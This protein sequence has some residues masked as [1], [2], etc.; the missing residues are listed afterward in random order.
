[1]RRVVEMLEGNATRIRLEP[2]GDAGIGIEFEVVIGTDT[3]GEQTKTGQDRWTIN[4]LRKEKVLRAAKAQVCA[5]RNYRFIATTD[6]RE[7]STLAGFANKAESFSDYVEF[8]TAE[9]RSD[10]AEIAEEW[11]VS[12]QDTWRMLKN[13]DVQHMPMDA[14]RDIVNIKLAV[15][16]LDDP[17]T[18][19][20]VLRGFCDKRMHRSFTAPEVL[21]YLES[22]DFRRKLSVGDRGVITKLRDTVET[23]DFRVRSF[24]PDIGLVPR[25]DVSSLVGRLRG[26]ES[27][28]I[29]VVAGTAGSG[30]STVVTAVAKELQDAGWFVAVA[31]MDGHS[32]VSTSF[33]LG[34]AMNLD[35]KPSVLLAGVSNGS[36][37][38]LVIDQ[39]DAASL[40]SGRMPENF[41]AVL[42][43]MHEVKPYPNVKV[44]L[45]T[46]TVDLRNDWRML[47]LLQS[48]ECEDEP[49]TVGK[50]EAQEVKGCLEAN[51]VSI[52]TSATTLELLRTPLHLAVFCRLPISDRAG[53]YTTLQEL[54]AS[55]TDHIR[56]RLERERLFGPANWAMITGA[57]VAYM[58]KHQVLS[59]PKSVLATVS[60]L[61]V[62]TL[63][64]ESVLIDKRDGYAF[65]HESYFDF[66]FAQDFVSLGHSLR[67]FLLESDQGLFRRAQTRQ[68]LEYLAGENRTRFIS[69]VVDLLTS[70]YV[71]F[72]LKDVVIAILRQIRPTGEDWEAL[73]DLAWNGS[74]IGSR[75]ITLLSHGGWFDAVDS[76]GLWEEWLGDPEKA[77]KVFDQV[78]WA[79]KERPTRV[80]ELIRPHIGQSDEWRRRCHMLVAA[81]LNR[82]L[83]DFA[84]ELVEQGQLDDSHDPWSL[85]YPLENDD[86]AGAVRLIGAF[87]QRALIRAQECGL[88]DPFSS[89]HLSSDSQSVSD[90]S[91]MAALE[92]SEF[93]KHVLPFVVAVSLGDQYPIGEGRLPLSKRWV[94]RRRGTVYTVEDAVFAGTC[95]ALEKMADKRPEECGAT[96]Q[97]LRIA[98][99]GEL[100]FL[101]CRA[102]TVMDDP[103]DAIGWLMSDSR[104]LHL[105]WTDNSLWASRELIEKHSSTCSLALL[106]TLEETLLDHLPP[107]EKKWPKWYGYSRYQL[108]S[109]MDT[110]RL[111]TLAKRKL[112][113]LERRFHQSPPDPPRPMEVR[114]AKSPIPEESTQH[115]SDDNWIRAL[116]K[117]ASDQPDWDGPKATGGAFELAQTLGRR[118]KEHPD[119]FARLSLRFDNQI[120]PAA[121]NAVLDNVYETIDSAL[122]TKVC[123]HAANTY[124]LDSGLSTCQAIRRTQTANPTT[125]RIITSYSRAQDDH[126]PDDTTP[127]MVREWAA[128]AAGSVLLSG[129]EHVEDLLPAIETLA[130]D[131]SLRVR[132]G[133]ASAVHVLSNHKPELALDIAEHLFQT[134]EVL[135]SHNSERL[136]SYAV[137]RRVDRFAPILSRALRHLDSAPA[138]RGSQS[139]VSRRAGRIWAMAHLH[140]LKPPSITNNISEL[141]EAARLGAAEALAANIPDSLKILPVLFD[142]DSPEVRQRASFAVRHLAR[143]TSDKQ[144]ELL[145]AL[146]QSRAFSDRKELLFIKLRDLPEKLPRGTIAACELAVGVAGAR[147]GDM[148]TADSGLGV[149]L[150]HVVLRLYRESEEKIRRRC[151]DIIDKL[152]EFNAF[153]IQ[154][155]LDQQRR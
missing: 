82:D 81:S 53:K 26:T 110:S 136:L 123:H 75:L 80:A 138:P 63:I 107:R 135:N 105:G 16:F 128:L 32:R 121:M 7:L 119:R 41:D 34:E 22:K 92:P 147:M 13:I 70:E 15:L 48:E 62:R 67:A 125:V 103:D 145:E 30:K 54:Y 148:R 42:K 144:S 114:S 127:S 33:E 86:P 12:E 50:L 59:S 25:S 18:V 5:G 113:E 154:T 56:L 141:P 51:N 133:A 69:V 57:L 1:M 111:S 43:T 19:F 87:L 101:A 137:L 143:L 84:V 6:A 152:V 120:P 155:R 102:L 71:R 47:R 8:L 99:S 96:I 66:I 4:Q 124:G 20:Q 46:R 11:G 14:L 150:S 95:D 106:T 115:M 73:N 151:L 116:K 117:Y 74:S 64:S 139:S 91:D 122:L 58:S 60:P 35:D 61:A 108:L 44:L 65:F 2:P 77:A 109:A 134:P 36:P 130:N 93:V 98:E 40:Y 76:L 52:P 90:I 21:G 85:L 17:D 149:Y 27:K 79:A 132:Y 88:T 29:I 72:H 118:A 104:N 126:K 49:H 140:K 37:A 23:Q 146:V 28:Q 131:H 24:E 112:Q 45:V 9:R 89:G 153:G 55:Y 3:W 10:L 100:R 142:D 68:V 83:V 129:P 78:V 31:R 38:L 97:D 39:L 94:F